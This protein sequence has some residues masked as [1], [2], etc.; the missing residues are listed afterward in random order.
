M[1]IGGLTPSDV[2]SSRKAE[3]ISHDLCRWLRYFC[4]SAEFIIPNAY[5][6]DWF[7]LDVLCLMK[8]GL[9]DEYEIKISRSDFL[10][11]AKKKQKYGRDAGVLKH[12]LLRGD[13]HRHPIRR[14]HYVCPEGLIS[15]DEVP[16]FAGLIEV[17]EPFKMRKGSS[18]YMFKVTK[19]APDL[20]PNRSKEADPAVAASIYKKMAYRY[21]QQVYDG[22]VLHAPMPRPSLESD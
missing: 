11:D 20:R 5:L 16:S 8:T 21:Q 7:E 4:T 17:L 15:V 6:D 19:Q 13:Y 12:D 9:V 3:A 18:A 10:V 1:I 22:K 2:T 14:F